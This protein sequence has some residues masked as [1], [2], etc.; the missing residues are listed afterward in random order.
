MP[1]P[2][3]VDLLKVVRGSHAKSFRF[4][5]TYGGRTTEANLPVSFAGGMTTRADARIQTTG[6]LYI[7][8]DEAR[9]GKSLLPRAMMD[10][11][12][13]FGQ[14]ITIT[15]RAGVGDVEPGLGTAG[16]PL[17]RF[18]IDEIPDARATAR[19]LGSRMVTDGVELEVAFTDAFAA[20]DQDEFTAVTAPK[21]GATVVSELRRI[22][23]IPLAIT[24]GDKAVPPTVVYK[25]NR[26]DAILDLAAVLDAVP[27]LDRQGVLRL[28]PADPF[29][30]SSAIDIDLTGTIADQT[31]SMSNEVKNVV[32]IRAYGAGAS[33]ILASASITEGPLSVNGPL[34]RRVMNYSS[35]LINTV[36]E[37]RAAVR[38]ILRDASTGQA[39][40]VTVRCLP[41]PRIAPGD[42]VRATDPD[43]GRVEVGVAMEIEW[44]F[45]P[46]A[47][48]RVTLSVP[49]AVIPW[50]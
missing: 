10:T 20:L 50:A 35:Q 21:P 4:D 19:R 44:S 12:A 46:T 18:T 41:D 37:A 31:N 25:E 15:M 34:G 39:K 1:Y 45:D 5:A 8:Q 26:L 43:S 42:K 11:L 29:S 13:P 30:I 24:I 3:N 6:R 14:G 36:P 38:R 16:I 28:R 47:L 33:E 22:C 32:V 7:R 48:M 49:Q 27:Y 9:E 40:T 23:T 17:G 2:M